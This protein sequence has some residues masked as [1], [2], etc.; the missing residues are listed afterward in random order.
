[1]VFDREKKRVAQKIREMPRD[2]Y[3][4][5]DAQKMM[6]VNDAANSLQLMLNGKLGNVS[7]MAHHGMSV[8]STQFGYAA[9]DVWEVE[10][11]VAKYNEISAPFMAANGATALQQNI[12][13]RAHELLRPV[14][15]IKNG[16]NKVLNNI[17]RM[18]GGKDDENDALSPTLSFYFVRLAETLAAYVMLYKHIGSSKLLPI[19]PSDVATRVWDLINHKKAWRDIAGR[20][21]VEKL[22][23]EFNFPAPQSNPPPERPSAPDS[24]GARSG[25][26]PGGSD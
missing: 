21:N 22:F 19:T 12:L 20:K 17:T 6:G 14:G 24:G 15:A 13:R 5:I 4:M 16:V 3:A 11:V 1:M 26:L 7:V 18:I 8:D 2:D 25:K 23:R 10:A 9:K